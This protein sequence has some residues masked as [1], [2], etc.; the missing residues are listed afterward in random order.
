MYPKLGATHVADNTKL[1]IVILMWSSTI[2]Y[3]YYGFYCT[4]HLQK[5][6]YMFV[7]VLAA[8]CVY[9]TLHPTF[10]RP[11]HRAYRAAMY[12]GLGLAFVVPVVHGVVIFGWEVQRRRMSLGWLTVMLLFNGAG[13]LVYAMR[14]SLTKSVAKIANADC[15]RFPRDG[16]PT[17]SMSG[18]RAI[19]SCTA[20]SSARAL[21]FCWG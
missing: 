20:W 10:R 4:S 6:Y 15:A 11:T 5:T 12:A 16:I 21:R 9:A 2:P 7:S 17:G 1:G 19:K 13:G 14:V 8:A 18:V 3:V